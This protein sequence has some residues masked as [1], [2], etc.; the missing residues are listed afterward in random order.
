MDPE[1]SLLRKKR[2]NELKKLSKKRQ[3]LTLRPDATAAA[4]RRRHL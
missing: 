1:K 4:K 3:I 2:K